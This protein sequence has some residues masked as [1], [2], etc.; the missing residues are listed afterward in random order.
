MSGFMFEIGHNRTSSIC[1]RTN[2]GSH[3]RQWLALPLSRDHIF[4]AGLG[5]GR[6]AHLSSHLAVNLDVLDCFLA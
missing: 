6:R 3:A 1:S 4:L 2:R 5:G